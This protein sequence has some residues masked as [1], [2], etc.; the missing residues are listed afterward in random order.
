[1]E[2][3]PTEHLTNQDEDCFNESLLKLLNGQQDF[4]KQSYNMIQ[5]IIHRQEYHNLMRD[6]SIY[7][8]KNMD[9][10]D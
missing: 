3:R 10:A 8:G 7:D 2:A 4:Q 5:D 1:M 9:L 6:I